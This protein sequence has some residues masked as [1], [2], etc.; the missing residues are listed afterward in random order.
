MDRYL[1]VKR[2]HDNWKSGHQR[3][4]EQLQQR[5]IWYEELEKDRDLYRQWDRE[6]QAELE[7]LDSSIH[8]AVRSRD[9]WASEH[10]KLESQLKNA[11][12][13]RDFWASEHSKL[14]SQLKLWV[15]WY[16][17]VA[18]ERDLFKMWDRDAKAVIERKDRELNDLN[19]WLE[20]LMRNPLIY[21]AQFLRGLVRQKQATH[22]RR[23]H[24]GSF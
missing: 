16:E 19:S 23:S 21:A 9:F 18:K 13:L 3:L 5:A 1:E 17:E 11:V 4:L 20:R 14:E 10:S 12:R 15:G 24:S 7:R 6:K 22:F 2:A 8:N